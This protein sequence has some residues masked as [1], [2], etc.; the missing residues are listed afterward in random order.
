MAKLKAASLNSSLIESS[1][2]SSSGR[3]M[4]GKSMPKSITSV[5]TLSEAGSGVSEACSVESSGASPAT[6]DAGISVGAFSG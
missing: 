6:K 4:S 3:G 5:R 1:K 2:G